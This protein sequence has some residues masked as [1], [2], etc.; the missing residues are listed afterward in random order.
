MNS[1]QYYYDQRVH[2]GAMYTISMIP[3]MNKIPHSLGQ[4]KG[5]IRSVEKQKQ[6]KVH[7]ILVP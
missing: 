4:S 6:N 5:Q 1:Y 2:I 7:V 3:S